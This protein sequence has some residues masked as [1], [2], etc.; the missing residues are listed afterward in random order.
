M[1]DVVIH[2]KSMHNCGDEEQDV[3]DFSTDGHYFQDGDTSCFSYMETEVTGL[4]GTR[5]S[6]FIR[7]DEVVVDRDG[8]ITS[9]MV[10]RERE[11]NRFQYSTPYGMATLGVNTRRI[12]HAFDERGGELEVDYV[13]DME[14]AVVSRNK[15][16]VK[17]EEQRGIN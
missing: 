4:E 12:R 1:K 9:R 5:T 2:M 15:I 3:I 17:I 8:M 7:P 16:L 13:L 11:K 10:F 6:V 14:H